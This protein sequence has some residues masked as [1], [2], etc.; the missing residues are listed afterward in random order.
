MI[1]KRR[2]FQPRTAEASPTYHPWGATASKDHTLRQ[3]CH[4]YRYRYRITAPTDDWSAEMTILRPNGG[5]LAS[6]YI[7]SESDPAKGYLK[8]RVCRPTTTYG[9]HK[10]KMKVTWQ[11]DRRTVSGFVKPSTFRFKRPAR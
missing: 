10:I 2:C 9:K 7:L 3:G 4:D 5:T 1:S 8:L 11:D 6:N